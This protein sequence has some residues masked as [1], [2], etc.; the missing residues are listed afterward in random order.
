[1][2]KCP[3]ALNSGVKQK[4]FLWKEGKQI[5]CP[6]A[7]LAGQLLSKCALGATCL[8]ITWGPHAKG[9]SGTLVVSVSGSGAQEYAFKN[10]LLS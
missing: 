6:D 9:S 8:T 7:F 4:G 1:M 2:D 3:P 10:K 5:T